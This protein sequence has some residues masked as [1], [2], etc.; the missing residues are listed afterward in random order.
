MSLAGQ[1]VKYFDHCSTQTRHMLHGHPCRPIVYDL[2]GYDVNGYFRSALIEVRKTSANAAS[3]GFGSNLRGAA[4]NPP[5]P[6]G[7]LLVLL[8]VLNNAKFHNE[9]NAI[10]NQM[11]VKRT[12]PLLPSCRDQVDKAI[13]Q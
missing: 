6:I 7:G 11:C 5:S 8:S 3:D 12:V 4:F 9:E 2:T 10:Y 13:F 1:R